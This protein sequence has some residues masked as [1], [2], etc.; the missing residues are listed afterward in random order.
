[1]LCFP[2]GKHYKDIV[3]FINEAE[4]C[5]LTDTDHVAEDGGGGYSPSACPISTSGKKRLERCLLFVGTVLC[6][7]SL[8]PFLACK[9]A[10]GSGPWL[11][12]REG[13]C[14]EHPQVPPWFELEL[15]SF[16]PPVI[17]TSC[18]FSPVTAMLYCVLTDC[19]K[20]AFQWK[21]C[22]CS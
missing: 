22:I 9:G 10:V 19:P 3:C 12:S 18:F 7:L 8:G 5:K 21:I 16:L 14:T 15:F 2:P 4:G 17:A 6:S 13:E 1:M 20:G 11:I